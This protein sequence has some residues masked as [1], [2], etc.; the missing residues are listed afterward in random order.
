MKLCCSTRKFICDGCDF[1]KKNRSTVFTPTCD[2]CPNV[3]GALKPLVRTIM[4]KQK[5]SKKNSRRRSLSGAGR[6][7]IADSNSSVTSHA[8]SS[9]G[10]SDN[11]A[12]SKVLFSHAVCGAYNEK[13]FYSPPPAR[14][15]ESID[16]TNVA[17][18]NQAEGTRQLDYIAGN[19]FC[20][21]CGHS[22]FL[23]AKCNQKLVGSTSCGCTRFMHLSC[24]RQAGFDV[25]PT[26]RYEPLIP[27]RDGVLEGNI[28]CLEH[29]TGE[30]HGLKEMIR[31]L[32]S[33]ENSKGVDAANTSVK[34]AQAFHASCK[35]VNILSWAWRWCEWWVGH[36]DNYS[37]SRKKRTASAVKEKEKEKGKD[38]EDCDDD[39]VTQTRNINNRRSSKGFKVENG[40][41]SKAGSSRQKKSAR[42]TNSKQDAGRNASKLKSQKKAV[43]RRKDEVRRCRLA[44]FS[45][46]LR[47]RDY[48][49]MKDLDEKP[50]YAAFCAVLQCPILCGKWSE[51][52]INFG[53]LWLCRAYRSKLNNLLKIG[54]CKTS[55]NDTT[56]RFRCDFTK[57]KHVLGNRTLPGVPS[58]GPQSSDF[59]R[60][61]GVAT[62]GGGSDAHN[63]KNGVLADGDYDDLDFLWPDG[64][65]IYGSKE[66]NEATSSGGKRNIKKESLDFYY[67]WV[68][69]ENAEIPLLSH[70]PPAS[71]PRQTDPE[72]DQALTRSAVKRKPRQSSPA[73]DRQLSPRQTAPGDDQ[74][75]SASKRKPRQ[76]SP[77]KDRRSSPR[78]TNPRDN[79]T[80]KRS[81]SKRKPRQSCQDMD[82]SPL[83]N[84]TST[85]KR[86]KVERLGFR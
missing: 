14:E 3:G 70:M 73:K 29:S 74:T 85:R 58:N 41:V 44:A 84:H 82:R 11:N 27:M 39:F 52:Q 47:N 77:A 17:M 13:V 80:P 61:D 71:P 83:R 65:G 79:Q 53:S 36:G 59:S 23:K 33:I 75:R 4:G 45:A 7:T 76:S 16:V 67:P 37:S 60:E 8:T 34:S 50:L 40:S 81:A 66:D 9:T 35:I 15:Y 19:K 22:Q 51:D 69:E 78:R 18:A 1:Y 62:E 24:A 5:N 42:V 6:C 38:Q 55:V 2:L 54:D 43:Q 26:G 64:S 21:L 49:S 72:D 25:C 63:R 57:F 56:C 46:A 10:D 32:M 86:V 48:D 20:I 12:L 30:D 68:K 31:M 28:G